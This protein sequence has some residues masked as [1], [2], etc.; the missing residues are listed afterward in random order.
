MFKRMFNKWAVKTKKTEIVEFVNHLS[1]MD[2]TEIALALA[3]T[4]D[5]RNDILQN[6]VDLFQ[7]SFILATEPEFT[8]KMSSRLKSV[9]AQGDFE[10]ATAL[11]IWIHTFR[12]VT[13]LEVRQS[14]R[15]LW[16]QLSRAF[17][18]VEE[19]KYSLFS[20]TGKPLNVEGIGQFPDGLTP[21]PR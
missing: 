8:H 18:L 5:L 7:P 6:G 15:D 12:A 19:E 14:G 9:Q 13:D 16:A 2:S 11:I 21:T 20:I 3:H 1:A 17:M 4:L 10:T